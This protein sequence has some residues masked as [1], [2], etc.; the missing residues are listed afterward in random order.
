MAGGMGDAG[1]LAF[2]PNKQITTG[3]GG[4]IAT[5]NP[6]LAG[7]CRSMRN[8]GRSSGD[9]WLRHV[10]LGYNYRLDELSAALGVAQIKRIDGIL[11]RREQ[12]AGYYNTRL[13]G[14]KG[15]VTPRVRPGV[16]MS[17]FVYVIRLERGISRDRVMQYLR[18]N[19]VDC[20]P[21]FKPIHLQP[22]FQQLFGYREGSFP[23]TERAALSTLALPFFNRITEKQMDYVTEVL[24][25]ALRRQ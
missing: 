15:V 17:W 6:G 5:D 10:R 21:Y 9:A 18:E 4:I 23:H 7:L 3:E 14:M 2:Y 19:G 11:A 20:R 1:V 16:N 8:Q 22:Y 13:A 12:V 24:A 25:E